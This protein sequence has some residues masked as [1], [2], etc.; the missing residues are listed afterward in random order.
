MGRCSYVLLRCHDVTIKRRGDVPLRRLS[1]IP[2][3]CCWVFHLTRTCDVTETY[4]RRRYNVGTVS[5]CRVGDSPNDE[6]SFPHK[7]LFTSRQV[8][9]LRKAF[10]N[11]SSANIQLSKTQLSKII[12]SG[13]FLGKFLGTLLKTGLPL[14]KNNN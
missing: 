9:N 4:M 11:N 5:F 6:T 2:L 1:D 12:Q 14:M 7:L 8:A 10:T 3:R 13:G